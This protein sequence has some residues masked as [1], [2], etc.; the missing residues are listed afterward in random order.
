MGVCPNVDWSSYGMA[1]SV[2]AWHTMKY[3]EWEAVSSIS[4]SQLFPLLMN[5]GKLLVSYEDGIARISRNARDVPVPQSQLAK[6]SF[7]EPMP[8]W[9][10]VGRQVYEYMYHYNAIH[11]IKNVPEF[12]VFGPY[13]LK[14]P[15]EF[16]SALFAT[17]TDPMTDAAPNE[18]PMREV[19][20][21]V[22]TPVLVLTDAV[23][24]VPDL[25]SSFQPSA[26]LT[27]PVSLLFSTALAV[28]DFSNFTYQTVYAS[29]LA[30]SYVIE[31]CLQNTTPTGP[32]ELETRSLFL[33]KLLNVIKA[34]H[35]SLL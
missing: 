13:T 25:S 10:S 12:P 2:M 28:A 22:L 8:S 14:A 23:P 17:R 33:L 19:V 31:W 21:P 6:V 1:T 32:L 35:P 15:G 34:V 27:R 11:M 3:V 24:V 18:P 5:T 30:A 20:A 9:F 16:N 4:T 29:V 26:G 7:L